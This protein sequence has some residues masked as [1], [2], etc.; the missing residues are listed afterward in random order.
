MM[1]AEF[2]I[3]HISDHLNLPVEVVRERNLYKLGEKTHFNQPLQEFHIDKVWRELLES[4]D[5]EHRRAQVTL[6]NAQNKHRKRGICALPT[7]FGLAFTARFLNQ[8]GALVHVYTDGSVLIT[9]GIFT[10]RALM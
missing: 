4:S 1:A 9:H 2:Y 8:A 10:S 7:K 6:F 5:F 3:A